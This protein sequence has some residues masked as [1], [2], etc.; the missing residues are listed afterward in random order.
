MPSRVAA[1][2]VAESYRGLRVMVTGGLGFIGSN[3]VRQ[4]VN[5]GAQVL[6]VDAMIPSHGGNPANLVGFE[7]RVRISITDLRD[8]DSM[9]D[10]VSGQQIIFNVAGQVSHVDSMKDPVADLQVN[11]LAQ[12]V[13]LEACRE[14]APEA[15]IVYASTRQIYGKPEY[16]PVDERHPICPVDANGI[17]KMA[18][19]F[20]IHF[21][22][23]YTVRIRFH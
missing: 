19:N 6:V 1:P 4:L 12:V 11:T 15:T 8:H 5:I 21:T 7:N 17:N 2:E 10:L 22:T 23:K 20:T 14:F 18:G 9:R 13:L 3:L 16:L